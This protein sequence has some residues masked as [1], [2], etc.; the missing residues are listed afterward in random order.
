MKGLSGSVGD[1][2]F[3]IAATARKMSLSLISYEGDDFFSM[4]GL[5][6]AHSRCS[7]YPVFGSMYLLFPY[8]IVRPLG[9]RHGLFRRNLF[10]CHIL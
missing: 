1:G 3:A 2:R 10:S 7:V 8:C 4:A 5:E 6:S 9:V